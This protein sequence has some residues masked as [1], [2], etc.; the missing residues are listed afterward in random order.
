MAITTRI[1]D[2]EEFR[3]ICHFIKE[4]ELDGRELKAE[5]FIAAFKGEKLC[6]FGRIREH[7]DCSELCSLGVLEK[8]RLQG[9][10]KAIVQ[11]LIKKASKQLYLVCIIPEFFLPYGFQKANNFPPSIQSKTDFCRHHLAVPETYVAMLK[12]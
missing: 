10:G 2:S 1:P 7:E 8:F 4:F 3:E 9:I 5:E 12:K 6:G 11:E